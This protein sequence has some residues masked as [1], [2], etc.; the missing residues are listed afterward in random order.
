MVEHTMDT[1]HP[2]VYMKHYQILKKEF[3]H[4]KFKRK[5]C[6]TLFIKNIDQY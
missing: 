1:G 6:K 2:P 3:N 5:I 4:C